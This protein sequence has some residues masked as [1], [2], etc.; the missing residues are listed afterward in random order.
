M[1]GW[2]SNAEMISGSFTEATEPL[3]AKSKC[4]LPSWI[5]A[6]T[7]A[8]GARRLASGIVVMDCFGLFRKPCTPP[9]EC[10][11]DGELRSL[12]IRSLTNT[13][14]SESGYQCAGS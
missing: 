1:F 2:C 4:T 7:A 11:K 6:A 3:A 14:I 10:K 12:E 5:A 13:D 9:E 8:A